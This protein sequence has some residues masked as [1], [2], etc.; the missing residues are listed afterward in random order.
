MHESHDTFHLIRRFE[1]LVRF[2]VDHA[3]CE[4]CFIG[5][6]LS[7]GPHLISSAPQQKQ[8]LSKT[9]ADLFELFELESVF[10]ERNGSSSDFLFLLIFSET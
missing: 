6:T 3:G 2:E 7:S 8:E 5:E 4:Y 9:E 10:S 1:S